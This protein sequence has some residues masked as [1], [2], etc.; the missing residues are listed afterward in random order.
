MWHGGGGG[1]INQ[2]GSTIDNNQPI[3]R[4][5]WGRNLWPDVTQAALLTILHYWLCLNV[6]QEVEKRI[7]V[8]FWNFVFEMQVSSCC[9]CCWWADW[10]V[11]CGH[12]VTLQSGTVSSKCNVLNFWV[13]L[14]PECCSSNHCRKQFTRFITHWFYWPL[15]AASLISIS[16]IRVL[17]L[18]TPHE[19]SGY[20]I[21]LYR[22]KRRSINS[23][24]W[25]EWDV[26][27]V[28]SICIALSRLMSLCGLVRQFLLMAALEGLLSLL[29][30]YMYNIQFLWRDLSF[31]KIM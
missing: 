29:A 14:C 7:I 16:Y 18:P 28:R 20:Q 13:R 17:V 23:K 30:S 22:V 4:K 10:H 8:L 15:P 11:L 26:L 6:N 12:L 5:E 31:S 21:A 1:D 3:R 25:W 27:D 19:G 2:W 9:L 24:Q